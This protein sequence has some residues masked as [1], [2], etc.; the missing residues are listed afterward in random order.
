MLALLFCAAVGTDFLVNPLSVN[1]SFL[2]F[3]PDFINV[4][5]LIIAFVVLNSVFFSS[6]CLY[7]IATSSKS[8]RLIHN[9]INVFPC[10]QIIAC[11][12][13]IDQTDP[14]F[15][16]HAAFFFLTIGINFTLVTSKLIVSTMAKME[17]CFI[18]PEPFVL[19]LYPL[20]E[21]FQINITP[22]TRLAIML[23]LTLVLYFS[24]VTT[25]IN[26][27]TSH[28]KIKCFSIKKVD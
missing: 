22:F 9:L 23:L 28:L 21:Y 8:G 20:C 25:A 18:Q 4:Q 1:I 24:F 26:Q 13:F 14:F 27:I 12:F 15:Q 11:Y 5:F 6:H 16:R 19:Y 17:F 7:E 10:I 3:L 2:F